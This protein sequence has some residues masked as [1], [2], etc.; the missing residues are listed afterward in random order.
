VSALIAG[1]LGVRDIIVNNAPRDVT[2]EVSDKAVEKH[3]TVWR[4]SS[5]IA[6]GLPIQTDQVI[7]VQLPISQALELGVK[8]DTHVDFSPSTLTN[9]LL[10]Q[11]II[12]LPEYQV[13]LGEP[14]YIDLLVTEGMTPYPLQVSDKN[15]INDYIR[16]GTYVDILTVSSPT[17][18]LAVNT[19]KP[20]SFKGVNANMFL[21]H[22]KVL[23]VDSNGETSVTAR[24]P[25]KEP[26]F[27][28]VV[29]E[30]TPD[31]LPRLAL[32]QRT[33]HIEIYRSQTYR[34]STYVEVRNIMDNY[35]G[36]EEFRGKTS[37]PGE[38]M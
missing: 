12:V 20:R 13:K 38:A 1:A 35:V 18:N 36:I 31:D 21:K 17:N 30:V 7:K 15:L 3:I 27:T 19:D 14:G 5:D 26:G 8:R 34:Q 28:T 16:P 22:V 2:N 37:M 6:K 9:R 10:P 4:A 24:A 32:A 25:T 11:G 29:I 33:M 23:N